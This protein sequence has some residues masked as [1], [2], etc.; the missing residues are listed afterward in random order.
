MLSL[1]V[2]H[3]ANFRSIYVTVST[4]LF[5]TVNRGNFEHYG[6]TLYAFSKHIRT[7]FSKLIFFVSGS[8]CDNPSTLFK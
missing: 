4:V 7:I 8:T 6:V 2:F 3:Y 5:N 1:V